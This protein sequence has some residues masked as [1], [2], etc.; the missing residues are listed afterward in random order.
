M[1]LLIFVSVCIAAFSTKANAQ[2]EPLLE[3]DKIWT[4]ALIDPWNYPNIE[5][6]AVTFQPDTVINGLTYWQS[7]GT[8]DSTYQNFQTSNSPNAV[9]REDSIGRV[10][11][12]DYQSGTEYLL[13]DFN[14]EL[15]DTLAPFYEYDCPTVVTDI[16]TVTYMDG[17]P[18]KLLEFSG[19]IN[20]NSNET[21]P[22]FN[23]VEGIGNS[24]HIFSGELYICLID[25]SVTPTNCISRNGELIYD[26][27]DLDGCF[28]TDT[29]ELPATAWSIF[30]NPTNDQLTIQSSERTKRVALYDLWGRQVMQIENTTT[31]DLS[32][33]AAGAYV[34]RAWMGEYAPVQ[35]MVMKQ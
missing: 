12:Y 7:Y 10:F 25:G 24:V 34:L 15:G 19:A 13:I 8:N 14:L 18:R 11:R 4:Y 30:P 16:R 35:R 1:K 28:L 2:F 17:L 6:F 5:S 29:R 3:E 32:E 21:Y 31:L 23:W 26:N 9:F 33:L 22:L 20:G 27:P